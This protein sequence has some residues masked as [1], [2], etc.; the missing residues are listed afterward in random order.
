MVSN[1]EKLCCCAWRWAKTLFFVANM[2]ASLFFVCAPPLLVVFLDLLIPFV[3]LAAIAGAPGAAA[4]SIQ[5]RSYRFGTSLVDLPLLSA[6]R[7]LLLLCFYLCWSG[8]GP[9]LGLATVCAAVSV[10]YV[11]LKAIAIFGAEAALGKRR[12]LSFGDKEGPVVEALFLSSFAL[13][14]AHVVAAYRTSCR[15]RRKLI[16]YKIDIEAVSVYNNDFS[17]YHKIAL[18]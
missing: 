7:S 6:A 11:S 13:A 2:L 16:V 14:M 17:N 18:S 4:M 5:L 3:L 12:L 10:G 15:E 8:K 9:Y 1:K